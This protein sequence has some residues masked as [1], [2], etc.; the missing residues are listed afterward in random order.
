MLSDFG[1]DDVINRTSQN[2]TKCFGNSG[3]FFWYPKNDFSVEIGY[4]RNGSASGITISRDSI[5]YAGDP[6]DVLVAE[7]LAIQRRVIPEKTPQ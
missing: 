6:V 3:L 2:M 5:R 1:V 4:C 7:W